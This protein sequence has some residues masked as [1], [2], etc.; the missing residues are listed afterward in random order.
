MI[1]VY[2]FGPRGS[3]PSPSCNDGFS[4]KEFGGNTSCYYIEAGPFRFI[5][6]MGSGARRLGQ[7]LLANKQFGEFI[8]GFSH[9][10]WDHVQGLPFFIPMYIKGNSFYIHGHEP[11][12]YDQKSC[13]IKDTVERLLSEQQTAPHFP[14]AHQSMPAR[15]IYHSHPSQ[16]PESFWYF[17]DENDKLQFVVDQSL[18]AQKETL[19]ASIKNDPKRWIK[20]ST[21][22][23]SHPNDCLGYRIDYMGNSFV[24]CTDNEPLRNPNHRINTIARDC[25]LIVLDG[26]YSDQELATTCQTFGHGSPSSCLEQQR[27]CNAKHC[28]IHHHDPNRDDKTLKSW[29]ESLK[30]LFSQNFSFAREGTAAKIDSS[31]I[32]FFAF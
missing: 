5:C 27:A 22:P 6:D 8:L 21:I 16:F 17:M 28:W 18:N 15:K 3:L 2:C 25:D 14:V 32:S 9:Y 11:P 24:Y 26:Q 7:F 1:T 23:L 13:G 29:E 4:T 30:E 31:D 20:I 10:H 12:G 19:P